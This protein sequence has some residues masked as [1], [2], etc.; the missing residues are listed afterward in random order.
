MN[1]RD[2]QLL[3]ELK[4]ALIEE[5]NKQ[6]GRKNGPFSFDEISTL[7]FNREPYAKRAL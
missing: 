2:K 4:G 5:R 3:I 7:G 6:K 1:G